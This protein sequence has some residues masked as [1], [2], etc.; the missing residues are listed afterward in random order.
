MTNCE[1]ARLDAVHRAL[2]SAA[3]LSDSAAQE[4]SLRR[5]L[6]AYFEAP[7]VLPGAEGALRADLTGLPVKA[8]SSLLLMDV[9]MLAH[10]N[11]AHKVSFNCRC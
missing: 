3:A 4:S 9:R 11:Q 10:E 8:T 1:A 5:S 6:Q 2:A 7:V